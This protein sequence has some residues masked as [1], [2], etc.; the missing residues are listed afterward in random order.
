MSIW[1]RCS[2][3]SQINTV[4]SGDGGLYVAGRWNHKG[5]QYHSAH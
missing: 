1:F 2:Q 5:N 4:F 3:S